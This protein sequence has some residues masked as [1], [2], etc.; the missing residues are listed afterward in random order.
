MTAAGEGCQDLAVTAAG[1]EVQR[2][3]GPAG[4]AGL[5]ACRAGHQQD[6]CPEHCCFQ[7]RPVLTHRSCTQL[8][9]QF[10][11]LRGWQRSRARSGRPEEAI[12]CC[13]HQEVIHQADQP[14][15]SHLSCCAAERRGISSSAAQP[16]AHR[17]AGNSTCRCSSSSS[18]AGP[19]ALGL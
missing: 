18:G 17:R 16:G 2:G 11:C 7:Q 19:R 4:A 3:G 10:Q 8:D 9:C 5:A 12:V 14:G 13:T 6:L 1:S 15:H